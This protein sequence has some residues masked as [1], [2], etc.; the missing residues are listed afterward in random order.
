MLKLSLEELSALNIL[1]NVMTVEELLRN[2]MQNLADSQASTD[3]AKAE[4]CS[5]VL[6]SLK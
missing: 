1:F 5:I 4:L 3:M 2:A 6:K